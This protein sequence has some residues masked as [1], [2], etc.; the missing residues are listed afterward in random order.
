MIDL[1]D[2]REDY[3]VVPELYPELAGEV[4]HKTVFTAINRQGVTFLWP[5]RIPAPDDR[6][7]D[8][9]RS[10]REAAELAMRDWIRVK[11]NISLGAYE[12]SVAESIAAE[13]EWEKLTYQELIQIGFR[14]RLITSL[15]HAVVRRLRGLS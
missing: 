14:D 3:L 12:V 6:K 9:P 7:S 11:A 15:D 13:P 5:V 8:W 1:K 2:D 10:E 4:V